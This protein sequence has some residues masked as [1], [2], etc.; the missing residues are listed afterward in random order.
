[1]DTSFGPG[2]Y[3]IGFWKEFIEFPSTLN[4]IE[5]S[6]D[7]PEK[8]VQ[9]L[10]KLVSRDNEGKQIFL[11]VSIQY[12]LLKPGLGK[13]YKEMTTMYEDIYISDLRDQLSKA[14]NQFSIAQAWTQYNFVVETMF[15]KC[16][17]ILKI[18]GA[19]CWGLQ[20]WGVS[21]SPK[22]EEQLIKTQVQKQKKQ[23]SQAQMI[24][25]QVRAETGFQL[26]AFTRDI[27]IVNAQ[28]TANKIEIERQAIATAEAN[29]V[30]AQSQIL[31]IIKDN[32]NLINASIGTYEANGGNMSMAYLSDEQL[33]T[34]QKYVM[35]QQQEQS[36]IIVDLA[37]GV[38]SLN[39]PS[40]RNLL[41]REQAGEL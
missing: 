3:W 37:D 40:T 41:A 30:Q 7:K 23:T 1:M 8:G 39:A 28:A 12:R 15:T 18:K 24:Q 35:L 13:I 36:H 33:V 22:Y 19:E 31:K 25:A 14:A 32:V 26:A 17:E 5:F 27:K 34:Y 21:L 9:H 29:L 6:D 20:L 10:S 11:D 38:G 16:K 2:R 4:T